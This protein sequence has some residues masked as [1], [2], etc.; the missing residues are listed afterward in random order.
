[1]EKFVET[2]RN[3]RTGGQKASRTRKSSGA[4]AN[5]GVSGYFSHEK[6]GTWTT[7]RMLPR[8]LSSPYSCRPARL[9]SPGCPHLARA[10][11][12]DTRNQYGHAVIA[13]CQGSAMDSRGAEVDREPA[14]VDSTSHLL[15]II[16]ASNTWACLRRR[17]SSQARCRGTESCADTF[18]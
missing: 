6:G 15:S 9:T 11:S 16:V 1:M 5:F 10:H 7:S 13:G 18:R 3:T 4:V 17:I 12:S 14:D 8:K 2:E